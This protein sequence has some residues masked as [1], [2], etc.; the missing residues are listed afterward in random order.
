[1]YAVRNFMSHWVSIYSGAMQSR[2]GEIQS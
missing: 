1:V 2:G